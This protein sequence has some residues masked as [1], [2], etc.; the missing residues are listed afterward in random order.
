MAIKTSPYH[1]IDSSDPDVY[2]DYEDCPS[3]QQI[4]PQNRREGTN[5]WPRCQHCI[6]LDS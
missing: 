6:N 1:S 2:H 5:R 3:G 4:P